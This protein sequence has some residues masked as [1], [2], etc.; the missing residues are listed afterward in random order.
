MALPR[1][2][3]ETHPTPGMALLSA[4]ASGYGSIGSNNCLSCSNATI[5]P[6]V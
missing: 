2:A 3:A 5:W 1:L 6:S 4:L